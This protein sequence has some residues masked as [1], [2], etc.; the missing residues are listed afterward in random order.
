MYIDVAFNVYAFQVTM[1][2]PLSRVEAANLFLLD[3]SN[4][5]ALSGAL[6]IS[7]GLV[8]IERGFRPK[9]IRQLEDVKRAF[10]FL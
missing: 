5:L 4:G 10:E 9:N 1:C 6:L 7:K 2:Q 3:L 8:A